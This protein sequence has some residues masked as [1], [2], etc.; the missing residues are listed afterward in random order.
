MSCHFCPHAKIAP[1]LIYMPRDMLDHSFILWRSAEVYRTDRTGEIGDPWGVPTVNSNGSDVLPLNWS[2]TVRSLRKEQHQL[3]ISGGKPRSAIIC[4]S[5][6]WLT[7][8]KNPWI[9]K[10]SKPV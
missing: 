2:L 3:T 6:L 9:S 7:L 4:V 1:L 10:R 8:S 5:H